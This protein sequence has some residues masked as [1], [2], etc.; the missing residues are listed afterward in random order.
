MPN[1]DFWIQI[2]QIGG[3]GVLFFVIA[4]ALVKWQNAIFQ[5]TIADTN[6]NFKTM[7]ENNNTMWNRILDSQTEREKNTHELFKSML[8]RSDFQIGVLT[9]VEQKIDNIKGGR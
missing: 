6:T 1:G 7:I 9:R 2:I 5:K 4:Y 3:I 8:D